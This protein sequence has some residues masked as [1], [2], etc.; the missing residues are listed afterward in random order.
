[1]RRVWDFLCDGRASG[2]VKNNVREGERKKGMWKECGVEV[3]GI[4][5]EGF[6]S[7]SI[8]RVGSLCLKIPSPQLN[9]LEMSLVNKLV[10][11][12]RKQ[13]GDAI[14]KSILHIT[15]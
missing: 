13:L 11:S 1:V 2:V 9:G 8:Q 7:S 15:D 3:I 10:D 14:G 12:I 5:N 4:A 6:D